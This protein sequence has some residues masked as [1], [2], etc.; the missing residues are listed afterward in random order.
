MLTRG[1]I[2]SQACLAMQ[3]L[4]TLPLQI[5]HKVG[6]L[7][8]GRVSTMSCEASRLAFLFAN[9]A[10]KLKTIFESESHVNPQSKCALII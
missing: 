2:Y 9:K 7:A 8:L 10:K 5:G 4:Y 6:E 1:N 3:W